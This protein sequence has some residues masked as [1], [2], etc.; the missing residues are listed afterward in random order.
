MNNIKVKSVMFSGPA[1]I[2][3]FDDGTKAV[4][5]CRQGDEYDINLGVSWAICKKVARDR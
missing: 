3:F 1:T 2:V 4:T 5:K